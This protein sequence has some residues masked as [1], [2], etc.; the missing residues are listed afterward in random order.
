MK[1]FFLRCE[2][3]NKG[4][5]KRDRDHLSHTVYHFLSRTNQNLTVCYFLCLIFSFIH[6]TSF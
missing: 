6:V 3:T 4:T 5:T 1:I 2:N